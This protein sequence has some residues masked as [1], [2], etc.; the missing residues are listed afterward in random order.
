MAGDLRHIVSAGFHVVHVLTKIFIVLVTLL[1]IALVPLVVVYAT[2]EN[3]F[4]TRFLEADN[5]ARLANQQAA[6]ALQSFQAREAQLQETI[7]DYSRGLSDCERAI[8][9]CEAEKGSISGRLLTAQSEA[10]AAQRTY[11]TLAKSLETNS[12]LNTTLVEDVRR[13]RSRALIAE[14]QKVELDEALRDVQSQ[15]QVAVAARRALQ[16]ELQRLKDEHHASLSHIDEYVARYGSL[17]LVADH[18]DRG[19]APDRDLDATIV[20]ISRKPDRTLVEI[21]AGSRDGVRPG[22]I[23][24][25][26][27][28][29]NFIGKLQIIEVD[30]NRSTGVLSLEDAGRG[31]AEIGDRAYS[32]SGQG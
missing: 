19:L 11:Q 17:D 28:E 8:A 24:T 6:A 5:A 10:T 25:V 27:D 14:R 2:N 22:W 16:E 7:N 13:L 15:L 31:L 12:D 3:T 30:I 4:R 29:G 21:D 9:E 1:A 32:L 26:G 23:M 18:G 20:D